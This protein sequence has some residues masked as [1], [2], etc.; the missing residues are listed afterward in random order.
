MP[1]E[2]IRQA[3]R[4][5]VARAGGP[6][7][8][9]LVRETQDAAERR[10]DSV[11][12]ASHV[13][14]GTWTPQ[15]PPGRNTSPEGKQSHQRGYGDVQPHQDASNAKQ[16]QCSNAEQSTFALLHDA[17]LCAVSCDGMRRR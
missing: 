2:G 6:H 14:A 4:R 9:A 5:R 1:L 10:N 7:E 17:R 3:H 11:V 16:H 15:A 12:A 13:S 8:D